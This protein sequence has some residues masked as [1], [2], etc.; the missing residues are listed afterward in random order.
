MERKELHA[1]I[2][3][4][5]DAF[6]AMCLSTTMLASYNSRQ[7][8]EDAHK[9]IDFIGQAYRLPEE[10]VSEFTGCILGDMMNIGLVTDYTAVSSREFMTDRDRENIVLYELK[11]RILEEVA[12]AHAPFPTAADMNQINLIR[13]QMKYDF[14]HHPYHPQLRLWQLE[15]LMVG[16]NVDVVRQVALMKALGI[17]CQKDSEK[18]RMLLSECVLWGDEAAVVLLER[19]TGEAVASELTELGKLVG[20]YIIAPKKD[21]FINLRLAEMLLSDKLPYHGKAELIINYHEKIW[22]SALTGGKE[23]TIG[24]RVKEHG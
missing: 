12:Q 1:M 21:P 3:D 22:K 4:N 11:G 16:G 17:G 2:Y 5:M 15:R 20:T 8:E 7:F 6:H 24:F 9:L 18:S 23:K 14:F 13:N 19:L 10:M